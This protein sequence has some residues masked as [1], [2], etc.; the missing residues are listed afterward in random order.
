VQAERR[1]TY[2][3]DVAAFRYQVRSSLD[4]SDR[5]AATTIRFH[6]QNG[7]LLAFEAPTGQNAGRTLTTWI[8][9]LHFGAVGALG[10]PY[11]LF[12]CAMGL[13]VT[14]LSVTGVWVWWVKRARRVGQR[15]RRS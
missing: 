7:D 14:A 3:P 6:G 15:A 8:Y 1:I 5:Y 11:R 13:A 12:V 10:L 4:I 2:E 9:Q